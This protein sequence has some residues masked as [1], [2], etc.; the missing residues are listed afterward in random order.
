MFECLL[1][2]RAGPPSCRS[3][4]PATISAGSYAG[5]LALSKTLVVFVSSSLSKTL[6]IFFGSPQTTKARP[7]TLLSARLLRPL[8][9]HIMIKQYLALS[10]IFHY[11]SIRCLEAHI[12][13]VWPHYQ[14]LTSLSGIWK[15]ASSPT[16]LF[17]F[18]ISVTCEPPCARPCAHS[19]PHVS[20]HLQDL[21]FKLK[22]S[23]TYHLEFEGDV[24]IST[25]VDF[26]ILCIVG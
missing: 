4:C 1:S 23:I 2:H 8:V 7:L 14:S 13:L 20:I 12:D 22:M 16:S 11:F 25:I 24:N 3:S 17:G 19:M 21:F 5:R 26:G 6:A 18:G 9:S 10:Y 15:H